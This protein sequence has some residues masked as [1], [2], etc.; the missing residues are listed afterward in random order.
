MTG[1]PGVM[2]PAKLTSR[3]TPT[4]LVAAAAPGAGRLVAAL[5]G[6]R[7]PGAAAPGRPLKLSRSEASST[8]RVAGLA[9]SERSGRLQN[10]ELSDFFQLVLAAR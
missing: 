10:H 1:L 3:L 9:A 6:R 7:L 8:P 2:I 4:Q 5:P